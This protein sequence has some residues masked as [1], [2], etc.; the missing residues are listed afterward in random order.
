MSKNDWSI[1]FR[2]EDINSP[3][4]FLCKVWLVSFIKLSPPSIA[5]GYSN[6]YENPNGFCSS[7]TRKSE[8][9]WLFIEDLAEKK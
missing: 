5:V 9:F 2:F 4:G 8:C 6:Q 7:R 1:K 3:F